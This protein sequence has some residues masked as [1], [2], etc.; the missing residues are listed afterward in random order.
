MFHFASSMKENRNWPSKTT[1]AEGSDA[2]SIIYPKSH[3]WLVAAEAAG[4]YSCPVATMFCEKLLTRRDIAENLRATV[5]WITLSFCVVGI[6]VKMLN[7]VWSHKVMFE[8]IGGKYPEQLTPCNHTASRE[9]HRRIIFTF[10][11]SWR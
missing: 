11:E 3:F 4:K 8:K 9:T 1:L 5:I 6:K 7:S 10:F 2:D